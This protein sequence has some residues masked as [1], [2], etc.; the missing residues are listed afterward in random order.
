MRIDQFAG[1]SPKEILEVKGARIYMFVITAMLVIASVAQYIGGSEIS[2]IM[3]TFFGYSFCVFLAYLIYKR[4]KSKKSVT[5][6]QWIVASFTMFFAIYARFNYVKHY[7]WQ[8]AASAMHL[9]AVTLI[10]IISLQYFYNRVLYVF[11]LA[12]Y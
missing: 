6:L 3:P 10:T 7:D 12:V 8:Y 11:F 5:A 1:F 4:K 2:I 9:A